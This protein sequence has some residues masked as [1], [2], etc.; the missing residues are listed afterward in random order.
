MP[1]ELGIF[2]GCKTFGENHHKKKDFLVLDRENHRYKRLIS[3][4]AGY[5]FPPHE[6]NPSIIISVI[7]DWLE[8]TASKKL[9]GALYYQERYQKFVDVL[10]ALCEQ[11]HTTPELLNFKAYYA[12]VTQWIF[13]MNS[14]LLTENEVG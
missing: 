8:E 1:Y 4:L 12:L 3:D 7:R 10:P 13:R 2:M 6:N 5:D 11:S 14:S 9:Q